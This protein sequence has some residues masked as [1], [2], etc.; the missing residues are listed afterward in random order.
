MN[1]QNSGKY[2]LQNNGA[3]VARGDVAYEGENGVRHLAGNG[4]AQPHIFQKRSPVTVK[5]A[6]AG[7]TR[8]VTPRLIP[9]D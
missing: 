2:I 6:I 5:F 9:V 8:N 7:V 4:V 1:M 3:F